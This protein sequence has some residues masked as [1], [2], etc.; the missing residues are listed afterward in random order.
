MA[1]EQPQSNDNYRVERSRI[2]KNL[3]LSLR[4]SAADSTAQNKQAQSVHRLCTPAKIRLCDTKETC[5]MLHKMQH[6]TDK[7]SV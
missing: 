7:T 6:Y 3:N 2:G 4:L 5:E 1:T